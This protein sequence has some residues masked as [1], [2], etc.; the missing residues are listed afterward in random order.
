MDSGGEGGQLLLVMKF[1]YVKV[2]E[3]RKNKNNSF[4]DEEQWYIIFFFNSDIQHHLISFIEQNVHVR[5]FYGGGWLGVVVT[6]GIVH[7]LH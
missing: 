2:A 3:R 4:K 1:G 5:E 6:T 7:G